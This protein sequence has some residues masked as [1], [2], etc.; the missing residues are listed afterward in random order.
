MHSNTINKE[1]N[2][3]ETTL[4]NWMRHAA[5][6]NVKAEIDA[7]IKT[8]AA[9]TLFTPDN[10]SEVIKDINKKQG[11]CFKKLEKFGDEYL[12]IESVQI[13][14]RISLT[15]DQIRC[16]LKKLNILNP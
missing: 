13:G 6:T 7:Q 12:A 2:D 8:S 16:Y 11:T 4:K 14:R 1:V 15:P 5:A 9:T 3:W 10:L